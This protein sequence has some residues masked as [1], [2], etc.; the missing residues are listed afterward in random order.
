MNL[1]L[2]PLPRLNVR[3]KVLVIF[4]VLSFICLLVTGFA[5]QYT[6][7]EMGTAATESSALLGREAIRDSTAALY[8][9]TEEY[10]LRVAKGQAELIDAIFWSSEAELNILAAHALSVQNNPAYVPGIRAYPVTEPPA[11]P[12]AATVVML[13]PGATVPPAGE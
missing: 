10:L 5:A 2:P 3:M 13:A 7:S 1:R 9:A 12:L 11:D 6:I 8:A 4:L